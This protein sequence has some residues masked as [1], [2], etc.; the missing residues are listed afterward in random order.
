MNF[1]VYIQIT[2]N[3]LYIL[4]HAN[5][6][7]DLFHFIPVY[8]RMVPVVFVSIVVAKTLHRPWVRKH[9]T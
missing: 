9:Y 6:V 5:S 3:V 8:T 4:F 1:Q 7:R 2:S